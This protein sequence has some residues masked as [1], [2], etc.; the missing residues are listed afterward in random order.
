VWMA[1][2]ALPAACTGPVL[3]GEKRKSSK[4]CNNPC[5]S[6]PPGD[7]SAARLESGSRGLIHV[8]VSAARC[9]HAVRS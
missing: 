4:P 3:S 6:L 7:D 1:H 2:A 8:D 5:N 9:V